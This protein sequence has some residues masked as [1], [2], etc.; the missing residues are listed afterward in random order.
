MSF[1]YFLQL[2]LSYS[3]AGPKWALSSSRP[4][5]FFFAKT[6]LTLQLPSNSSAA[7][8]RQFLFGLR[9]WSERAP[10]WFLHQ[11]RVLSRN[12][13]QPMPDRFQRKSWLNFWKW[14]F[15]EWHNQQVLDSPHRKN[16]FQADIGF[17]NWRKELYPRVHLWMPIYIGT[18]KKYGEAQ[19]WRL[20]FPVEKNGR[21]FPCNTLFSVKKCFIYKNYT[22]W[23]ICW[24]T[25]GKV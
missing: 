8:S 3:C 2:T 4:F 19:H 11:Y 6:F 7:I 17:Q 9:S 20:E 16:L 10:C 18:L 12:C 1:F 25:Y 24:E 22:N 14:N 13:N 15:L 21:L 23:S 5:S